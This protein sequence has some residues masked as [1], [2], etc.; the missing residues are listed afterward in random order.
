MKHWFPLAV[1]G[2]ILLGAVT[3][4]FG[5][6]AFR[7]ITDGDSGIVGLMARHMALGQP[8]PA[9]FYGQAY[10]GNVE[11]VV[12]SLFC[13]LLG[14]HG[15]S[16]SLGSALLAVLALVPLALWARDTGGRTAALVAVVL[17]VIGPRAYYLFQFAPRGGYMAALL[18][19]TW[20]MFYGSRIA[21]QS[22]SGLNVGA[23][24]FLLL[25]AGAGLGW[26]ANAIVTPA[27]GAT[28]LVLLV[29]LRGRFWTGQ[30]WAGLAGFLI[31]SAPFW[32]W[33][34]T[35]DWAS[36]SMLGNVGTHS[37]IEGASLLWSRTLILVTADHWS[38]GWRNVATALFLVPAAWGLVAGLVH[39][40]KG[41]N[42]GFTCAA[43]FL[44]LSL[45][46]LVRS[47]YIE[48]ST[49]RY[50][51]PLVPALALLAGVAVART[52]RPWVYAHGLLLV[53]IVCLQAPVLKESQAKNRFTETGWERANALAALM[54][55]EGI[56][57][58]YCH[59][60]N[61]SL[62]FL[63]EERWAFTDM[64]SERYLPI[65]RRAELTEQVG[66]LGNF[67]PIADFLAA[68]GGEAELDRAGRYRME[69]GFVPPPEGRRE[70]G[71]GEVA[72][73]VDGRG[74]DLQPVLLDRNEDTSWDNTGGDASLD[75]LEL[76]FKTP[77]DLRAIRLL[78]PRG[79][80][81]PRVGCVEVQRPGSPDWEAVLE[82]HP[83]SGFFWSGPRPYWSRDRLRLEYHLDGRPVVGVRFAPAEASGRRGSW[84]LSECRFFAVAGEP[85]S[86]DASWE[87]LVDALRERSARRLYC[88]RWVANRL[89][90]AEFDIEVPLYQVAFP[91]QGL[92]TVV[93][94]GQPTAVLVP[95]YE[96]P[97]TRRVLE[98]HEV[99]FAETEVARWILFELEATHDALRAAVSPVVWTGFGLIT[100]N[101]Q[102]YA[103][104]LLEASRSLVD[105]AA[106]PAAVAERI[107]QAAD[108][109]PGSLTAACDLLRWLS[110]QGE[111]ELGEELAGIARRQE[112]LLWEPNVT[113]KGGLA[114]EGLLVEPARAAPGD[115]VRM[116]YVWRCPPDF[117]PGGIVVFMHLEG[118]GKTVQDDH[119]LLETVDPHQIQGQLPGEMF[120]DERT[121]VLPEDAAPGGYDVSMGLYR[122]SSGERLKPRT[123]RDVE[124]RALVLPE[125]LVV[126]AP[127]P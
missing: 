14:I 23:G 10:M 100:G 98:Q 96:A 106:P 114:L 111:D 68:C 40:R 123:E 93:E 38:A 87:A 102:A 41:W 34:M 109:Y 15:F 95:R 28:A 53:G 78:G 47:D 18:L 50:L 35:H 64:R 84:W 7:F 26:Y 107:W 81:H 66:V 79:S 46:I 16:V 126:S 92:G 54:E 83:V 43:L 25:G 63:L 117:Y 105:K 67:G 8:W 104:A 4:V 119:V 31:G 60:S 57:A 76:H 74:R 120:V 36:F 45:V 33:N 73:L 89:H 21:T 55:S 110:V 91:G 29:G 27:L 97:A 94:L 77:Q 30:V 125:A 6:W 90:Q 39:L 19:G 48:S 13:R 3:R 72:S 88:P 22:W 69:H 61:H 115:E 112:A 51:L 70:I 103:G 65:A 116:T 59:F 108:V 5:A 121:L 71:P 75:C 1:G 52:P 20:V 80:V 56:D 85:V 37:V 49:G 62:N 24:S 82:D 86:L 118:E 11:P 42:A 127:R 2:L 58:A 44:V 99:A 9:F 113:F 12:S 124:D 101:S 122:R 17:C 32:I